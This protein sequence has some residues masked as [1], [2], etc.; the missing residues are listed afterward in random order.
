M[1]LF[2]GTEKKKSFQKRNKDSSELQ[3]DKLSLLEVFFHE[4]HI[5]CLHVAPSVIG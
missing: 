1:S 2:R 4:I 5:W 3:Q